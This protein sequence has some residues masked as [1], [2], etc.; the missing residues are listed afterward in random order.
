MRYIRLQF[1]L[2]RYL[3]KDTWRAMFLFSFHTSIGV[4]FLKR[5][6]GHFARV[7]YLLY[8]FG[9]DRLVT[10][11][12][13]LLEQSIFSPL[14]SLWYELNMCKAEICETRVC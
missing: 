1:G 3:L 14:I 5:H 7:H 11:G 13:L 2:G 12:T 8:L 6:T 10:K 9:R 4:I